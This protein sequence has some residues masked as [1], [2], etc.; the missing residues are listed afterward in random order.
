MKINC[1]G[2]KLQLLLV[3]PALLI[4]QS[5]TANEVAFKS[6]ELEIGGNLFDM[7]V[8][9]TQKQRQRG[10]MYRKKLAPQSG[11]I[12]LF[13]EAGNNNIWMKNTL[14]PLTVIWLDGDARVIGIKKLKPCRQRDCPVYGVNTPSKFI[15]E[16][17]VQFNGLK[18][19]DQVPSLLNLD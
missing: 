8:A 9:K 5:L 16:L 19:G 11:M 13:P 3:L 15:I 1:R 12:F 7:E 2:Y 17:N 4:Y 14:I 6:V 10:L 18:P